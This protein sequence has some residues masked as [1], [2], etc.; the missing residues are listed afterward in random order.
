MNWGRI[1]SATLSY[2]NEKTEDGN[3]YRV[4]LGP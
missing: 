1:D 4:A 2:K 3:T